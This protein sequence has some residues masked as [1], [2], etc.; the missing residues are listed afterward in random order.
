MS[1]FHR[2]VTFLCAIVAP[3]VETLRFLSEVGLVGRV[4]GGSTQVTEFMHFTVLEN[5]F[6]FLRVGKKLEILR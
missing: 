1:G 4:E 3:K 5:L 6:A 2:L